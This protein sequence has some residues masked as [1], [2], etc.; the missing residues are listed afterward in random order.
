MQGETVNLLLCAHKVGKWVN[1]I[2]IIITIISIISSFV[3]ITFWFFA[4]T[5]PH[6]HQYYFIRLITFANLQMKETRR[7]KKKNE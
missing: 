7:L 6:H 1:G 3:I 4:H 5:H 2:I